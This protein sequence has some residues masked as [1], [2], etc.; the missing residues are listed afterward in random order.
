MVY[1]CIKIYQYNYLKYR[2]ILHLKNVLVS[3]IILLTIIVF[4][5]VILITKIFIQYLG[6]K[7]NKLKKNIK[8]KMD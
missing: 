8:N 3:Y 1:N 7:K 5:F 4:L 6:L 2:E